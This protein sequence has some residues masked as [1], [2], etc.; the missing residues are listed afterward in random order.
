MKSVICDWFHRQ[1]FNWLLL[2]YLMCLNCQVKL[3]TEKRCDL[4]E[5]QQHL[6]IG[7]QKIKETAKQVEKLRHLLSIKGNELE[8]KNNLAKAKMK[9]MV[10]S[11]DSHNDI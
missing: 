4:E 5:Q 10:S 9:Q 1:V 3:F 11:H 2:L 8:E 7:L 6:K